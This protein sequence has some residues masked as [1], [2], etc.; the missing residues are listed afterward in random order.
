MNKSNKIFTVVAVIGVLLVAL[1]VVYSAVVFPMFH[2]N[3]V[4]LSPDDAQNVKLIAHRGFSSVAPENSIAAIEEAGKAGFYGCEFDI[5]PTSDGEWVLMHDD[6]VKRTTNG[7]GIVTEMTYEDIA[8]LKIDA[9]RNA[10]RYP[11]QSVPR[12][13]EVLG[14]CDTYGIVPIVEIKGGTVEQIPSMLE[15]AEKSGVLDK[16]VFISFNSELLEAVK[17]QYED[18]TIFYLISNVTEEDID[19]CAEQGFGLNFNHSKEANRALVGAA[20]EKGVTC[21]AWTVDKIKDVKALAKLGVEYITTNT[22]TRG[23]ACQSSKTQDEESTEKSTDIAQITETGDTPEW[24]TAYLNFLEQEKDS[25]ESY[26]LVYIDGDSIPELYLS[27]DYEATGDSIC[28]YKNGA[29]V[30]QHLNRI[31]GGLYIEKSGNVVN[32]NGNMGHIYTHVYKLNES[33]FT[34]TFEALSAERVEVL[35][36]D[37]YKLHYEYS[38]GDKSVNESEYTSAIKA[39]FDFENAVRLNEN[40]VNYD[41]IQQQI[42][43]LK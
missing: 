41:T 7:N 43:A 42:I 5:Q 1:S 31:G 35:E 40:E 23:S 29:V 20:K 32:Q 26:A 15:V 17:A 37:E 39:A 22:V 38:I 8:K 10:G 18:A 3:P 11:D 12:F 34:L 9:G 30:E 24:K 28:T 19:Y 13:D 16:A 4:E 36:N 14:I 33:G 25:H 6:D 2:I 27:G 21:A